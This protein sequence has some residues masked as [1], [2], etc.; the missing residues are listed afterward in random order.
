MDDPFSGLSAFLAVAE[1]R[2][3]TA[4]AAH[5]GVTPS[6]VS[7]AVKLL[8]ERLGA[9]LLHRTTRSVALTEAGERFLERVR[10]AVA[11]VE[12]A[13]A[14]AGD[15][16]ERPVGT[17][18]LNVPKF[19][20]SMLLEPLLAPLLSE[21]PGLTLEVFVD[22]GLVNIV[23]AG[24]DAGV[25]LG[26]TLEQDMIAV[27]MGGNLRTAV[28]GAPSYLA[29]R[30]RPRRPRDLL[31]HDCIRYR[32]VTSGAV[33]RWEFVED[34]RDL[35][36]A[37]NGRLI[38]NDLDVMVRAAR[39]GLGLAHVIRESVEEHLESGALVEL[40][41]GYAAVFPGFHLYYPSR[42]HVPRKLQVLIDRLKSARDGAP[43]SRRRS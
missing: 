7:Q 40:L 15:A 9:R 43:T 6:A 5:L 23:A 34:G 38:V 18:R 42:V 22:D 3:F 30:G 39:D 25:R 16:A 32:R 21:N 20:C 17:L 4:A 1:R 11:V 29:A 37:V 24:F 35:A 27:K 8:E 41:K 2:S 12:D 13:M 36:I 33:Y 31:R 14:S 19:A 10:P 26:E 28:V